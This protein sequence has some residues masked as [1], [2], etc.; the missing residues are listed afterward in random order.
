MF[1]SHKSKYKCKEHFLSNWLLYSL[2]SYIKATPWMLYHTEHQYRYSGYHQCRDL[3]SL[4]VFCAAEAKDMEHAMLPVF[5]STLFGYSDASNYCCNYTN[6]FWY[7]SLG[8]STVVCNL[9]RIKFFRCLCSETATVPYNLTTLQLLCVIVCTEGS[10]T[11]IY[12]SFSSTS[13]V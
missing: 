3:L 4:C 10:V 5:I 2:C 11:R 7:K 12:A 1:L 8:I 6:L 13:Y 9:L